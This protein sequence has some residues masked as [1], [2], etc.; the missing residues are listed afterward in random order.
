MRY[1][2]ILM[3]IDDT[4]FDFQPGNRNA[5]NQLME[6]LGLASPTIYDEYEAINSTCWRALE[7]G[8][9]T[10]EVLHVERFRRFLATKNR[11][12]D[13]AQV[14]DRFA[15]LLGQQAIPLPN[16][17]ETLRA[18][19][20][21]REVILLTNGITVIQKRRLACSGIGA[22]VHG[23]VISQEVGAS[24]PDPRIFEIALDGLKPEEALMIGD[25][26]HSD[27]LGA[28]RAGADM[29]WFNP[30]GKALP[31]GMHAEYEVQDIRDCVAIALAE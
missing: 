29:C 20:A 24:K 5:V 18:I 22:W 4:I 3:D 2:R 25:G 10:Q 17:L 28:N 19:A 6:E 11:P 23:V 15:E 26:I 9:M 30:K 31:E 12:D 27:V 8:E 7:R 16:A 21:E 13:P 14:A 1:K